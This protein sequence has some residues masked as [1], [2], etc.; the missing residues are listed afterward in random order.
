MLLKKLET[1]DLLILD[2]D[3]I[4]LEFTGRRNVLSTCAYNGGYREDLKTIFNFDSSHKKTMFSEMKAPTLEEHMRL[5]AIEIGLEPETSTGMCTAAQMENVAIRDLEFE[6][7]TVTAIVTGGIDINGAR[8]GDPASWVERGGMIESL[9]QVSGTINIMLVIDAAM[10]DGV[11]AYAL[12]TA[13]EAK[14][15]AIQELLLPS[16][17]S[18]GIATGSGTDKIVVVGNPSSPN[19]ITDVGKHSKVGEMIAR[20]VIPAIK[21]ALDKQ[22]DANPQTQHSA[23]KRMQRFGVT[24]EQIHRLLRMK[25]ESSIS[26]LYLEKQ[27]DEAEVQSD[28]VILASLYAHL[29]DQYEWG[30]LEEQEV[31]Q[32]CKR[33]FADIAS[34][35]DISSWNKT[36]KSNKNS[37]E[38]IKKCASLFEYAF[39]ESIYDKSV[40][41]DIT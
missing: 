25:C 16:R 3:S 38:F 13:T 21:E 2:E 33:L 40:G 34:Y 19:R 18:N 27:I 4:K 6:G 24:K 41:S 8:A 37:Q 31:F 7:V 20:T 14:A 35:E 22:T 1:N 12:M 39:A 28:F 32:A 9:Q 11:L 5:T 26:D 23:L 10:T 29:L 30:L 15:A 17:Y 36:A